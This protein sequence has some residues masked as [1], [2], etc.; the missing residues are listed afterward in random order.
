R[1]SMIFGHQFIGQLDEETR[2]AIFG[3]VGS[4]MSFRIGPEDAKYLITEFGPVFG[5]EDL[6]NIDNYNAAFRLL[7]KGETSKPFNILTYPPSQGNPE[8]ARLIKEY[9]RVKYGRD[10]AKVEEELYHRLQKKSEV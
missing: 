10:R 3:N 5:E 2:K 4:M 8:V 1:L 9:S 6:V 7:I